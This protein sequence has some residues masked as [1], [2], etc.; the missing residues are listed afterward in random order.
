MG[1]SPGTRQRQDQV[2]AAYI[3]FTSRG[4]GALKGASVEHRARCCSV[5]A[6]IDACG[7]DENLRML[8]FSSHGF[9]ASVRHVLTMLMV[10][11]CICILLESERLK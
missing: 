1:Q 10:G 2:N 6:Q 11:G 7:L 3:I 9:D 5:A 8:Q 4:T